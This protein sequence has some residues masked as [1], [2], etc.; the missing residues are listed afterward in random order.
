MEE[1]K[2][3]GSLG[4]GGVLAGFIFFV[5][6]QDRNASEARLSQMAAEF[7]AI[8]QENT[9]ALTKLIQWLED[10]ERERAE[11]AERAAAR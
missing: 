1:I 2:F 4:V 11:R 9:S 6:R 7:R 3:L 5:Y 8:V 10:R